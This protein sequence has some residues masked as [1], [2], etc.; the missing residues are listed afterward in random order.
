MSRTPTDALSA[1]RSPNWRIRAAVAFIAA[2]AL[3]LGVMPGLGAGTAHAGTATLGNFRTTVTVNQAQSDLR[4]GGH[5]RYDI[6]ARN[7]QARDTGGW[8]PL[9]NYTALLVYGIDAPAGL[10]YRS[11]GGAIYSPGNWEQGGNFAG[12]L[13]ANLGNINGLGD[14]FSNIGDLRPAFVQGQDSRSGWISFNIPA[15]AQGGTTYRAGARL[16]EAPIGLAIPRPTTRTSSNIESFTLGAVSSQTR[17]SIPPAVARVGEPVDLSATV[18]AG[19]GS[20]TPAGTITFTADGQ[21]QTAPVVNGVATTSMTFAT[22]G[23]KPVMASFTPSNTTQWRASTATG[24]VRVEAEATQTN[25]ELDAVEIISGDTISATANVTPADADGAVEFT[26]GDQTQTVPVISGSA[27]A[28]FTLDVPENAA[29]TAT[30]IPANPE[31][32][33]SSTDTETVTVSSEQTETSVEISPEF[34]RVGE[35]STLRATVTPATAVG[36]VTFTV[37]GEEYTVDV[38]SGEAATTHQ[39]DSAGEF[40]VTAAFAPTD[41]NRYGPS[42][43]QTTAT[44][45][46]EATETNLELDAI[47]I[48]SGDTLL[49]TARITPAGA[50]GDVQFIV[51]GQNQTIPLVDGTAAAEF[52]LDSPGDATVTATFIPADPARYATSSD[53]ETVSVDTETTQLVLSAPED[54]VLDE[55]TTIT[56]RVAPADADGTVTFTIDGQEYVIDVVDGVAVTEHTFAEYGE[57]PV[58]AAFTPAN[59]DRYTSSEAEA[60]IALEPATGSLDMGSLGSTGGSSDWLATLNLGSLGAFAAST[61]QSTR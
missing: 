53:T 27:N 36:T 16:I 21:S 37:D 11:S 19:A 55:P 44:V 58:T 14:L 39:F 54:I 41:A 51:N 50:Q 8:F 47:E 15:N 23:S 17:I 22:T 34:A 46:A 35:D 10:T 5:V 61:G 3:V 13:S 59:P 57:Y 42:T 32:Y 49:A 25:L 1:H 12:G 7:N 9:P 38:V 30:F 20:N 4:P 60:T 31:R 52:T 29:V 28:E 33:T 18:S 56:A 48:L 24:T 45:Q 43:G 2:V 40:P 6:T 26:V